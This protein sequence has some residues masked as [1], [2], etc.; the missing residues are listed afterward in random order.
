M[1]KQYYFR[2]SGQGYYAWD[3]D[4]LVTLTKSSQHLWVELDSIREIDESFWF[5]DTGDKPT[6]R[7]I[8]VRVERPSKQFNSATTLNRIT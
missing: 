2:P 7:A 3:V 1:R 6:C 8:V 4:R 5:G